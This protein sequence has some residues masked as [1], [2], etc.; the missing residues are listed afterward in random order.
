MQLNL[1]SFKEDKSTHDRVEETIASGISMKGLDEINGLQVLLQ[2]IF[3]N[4]ELEKGVLKLIDEKCLYCGHKLKRK[5]IYNKEIILPGGVRFLLSF[6][7]YSCLNCKKKVDRKLGSWF[8][9]GDR[10]S[11]NVK[12]DATRLYLSHLSSYDAVKEELNKLYKL[13][14]SK[15]TVRKWLRDLES[16][17]T[18]VLEMEQ[19]FSGHFI[20]D[21]EYIKVFEGEV[22]KKDA[23]LQRIEVYLLL[24]R[25]AITKK[26]IFMLSQSLDKSELIHYWRKFVKWTSKNKIPFKTL[27]TDGKREYNTMIKELNREFG[28]KVEHSYC[29]FHFKKNLYEVCNKFIYGVMQTK[30]ELPEHIINQIKELERVIDIPTKTEFEEQLKILDSQIQTFVKPLQE[31]I[32]RMQTYTENYTLHKKYP[33]LRTTNLAEHWFGQ[34]KPEK[35]KKGYKTKQGFFTIIQLL[36]VKITNANWKEKLHLIQDVSTATDLLISG[37]IKCQN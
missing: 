22:G 19:E 3:C 36:G 4:Y 15:K 30:K 31:Q 10:Y 6:R 17:S 13:N 34:T 24:F 14:L 7:Q 8:D 33:F 12:S 37:I 20:Y 23:K 11:T 9:K 18:K 1:G 2:D 27:T 5:G 21:E 32:K 16:K 29:I 25:D 28:I 35:I 26:P